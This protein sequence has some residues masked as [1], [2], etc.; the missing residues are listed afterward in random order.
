VK[1]T[2]LTYEDVAKEL[3]QKNGLDFSGGETVK[4]I[5]HKKIERRVDEKD[6]MFLK[7]LA[8][9]IGFEFFVR[10]KT[11][12][13]RK[14]SD[15]K[16]P[17][18]SFELHNNIINFSPRMSISNVVSE[19][20]VTAWN[21]KDKSVISE[22]A[23]INELKSSIGPSDF[24]QIVEQA[25]ETKAEVKVEGRVVRSREEAKTIALSELKRRNG[26]YITG[27]LECAGNAALRPGMT[28]NI[29]K[30]GKR[31]SGPYYVK[32]ATHTLGDNGYRTTLELRRCL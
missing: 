9:E 1:D 8:E 26:D 6:Y 31:F 17:E 20:R 23:G 4:L 15:D 16:T 14:A 28:V 29:E 25:H 3:A 24:E 32:K 2:D 11:L 10:D 7:R 22:N 19:V 13:F 18:L 30:V 21:E 27:T 5:T 12:Y